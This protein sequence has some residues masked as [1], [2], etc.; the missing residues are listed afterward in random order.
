MNNPF[1][2]QM[3]QQQYQ[4]IQNN[5]MQFLRQM[6]INIP[7]DIT[8]DP[9]AILQYFLSSGRFTQAQVNNAYQAFYRMKQ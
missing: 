3:L 8:N 7:Q 1:N 6:N 9:N 4:A 2:M 5:P